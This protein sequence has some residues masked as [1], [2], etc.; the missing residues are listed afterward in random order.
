MRI[1]ILGKPL[2]QARPRVHLKG[3]KTFVYDPQC[4][5]KKVIQYYMKQQLTDDK[6]LKEE[7]L[8]IDF[9]FYMPVPK[10]LSKKVKSEALKENV[11]HGLRP[12]ID[13]LVKLYLDCLNETVIRDDSQVSRITAQKIYGNPR[14]IINIR[15]L[16]PFVSD[17]DI[18]HGGPVNN[19]K[20]SPCGYKSLGQADPVL[21]L[22]MSGQT[23]LDYP[24]IE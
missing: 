12:D 20:A 7:N 21:F 8:A 1:E 6:L 9:I 17:D 5:N 2:P 14:T 4:R 3:N 23:T 13:N 16:S 24:L 15:A 18:E 19:G 10:W 22:D 11:Y